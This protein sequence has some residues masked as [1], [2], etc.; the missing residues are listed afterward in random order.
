MSDKKK[1]AGLTNAKF[2]EQDDFFKKSCAEAGVEPTKRQ[3]SKFRMKKG[4][5]WLLGRPVVL[6]E[7]KRE[8]EKKKDE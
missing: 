4:S 7:M 2:A 1:T 3:A 6:D 8:K 5:A